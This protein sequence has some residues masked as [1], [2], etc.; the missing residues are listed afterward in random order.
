MI[1]ACLG[2]QPWCSRGSAGKQREEW[3][4]QSNWAPSSRPSLSRRCSGRL[5]LL[6]G[7]KLMLCWPWF[8]SGG[9]NSPDLPLSL[10]S[11]PSSLHTRLQ[12]LHKDEYLGQSSTR[13]VVWA[14]VSLTG[15]RK[16]QEAVLLRVS[17]SLFGLSDS[18]FF[19]PRPKS[20]RRLRFCIIS[21]LSFHQGG[22]FLLLF[23]LLYWQRRRIQTAQRRTSGWR[24]PMELWTSWFT[25]N[26]RAGS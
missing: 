8:W 12:E 17:R 26:S 19:K 4:S 6:P 2:F 20:C 18:Y 22:L 11:A 3:T 15:D 14:R 16:E 23:R 25:F 21:F 9:A 5:A 13:W 10:E 1:E 7:S 24:Y